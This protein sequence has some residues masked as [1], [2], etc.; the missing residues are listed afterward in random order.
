MLKFIIGMLFILG[1]IYAIIAVTKYIVN[2]Y[3]KGTIEMKFIIIILLI[4]VFLPIIIYLI[5]RFNLITIF[6]YNKNVDVNNWFS[7]IKDYSTALVSSLINTFVVIYIAII[8]LKQNYED[9]QNLNKEN[10]RLQNLPCLKISGKGDSENNLLDSIQIKQKGKKT[11]KCIFFSLII[12]NIGLNAAKNL[13]ICN[14]FKNQDIKSYEKIKP[15]DFVESGTTISQDIFVEEVKYNHVE[16]DS[17]IIYQDLLNNWYSLKIKI[18][19]NVA[20]FDNNGQDLIINIEQDEEERL[21]KA[22]IELLIAKVETPRNV[23][24]TF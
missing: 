5:D 24:N 13:Y 2:S 3:K 10:V 11:D 1:E 16:L 12:Q 4:V 17:E 20:T 8:E 18:V 14:N 21:E 22:P 15:K 6:G 23:N 9:D 19:I 7:F